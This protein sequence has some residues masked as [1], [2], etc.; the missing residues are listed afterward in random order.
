MALLSLCDDLKSGFYSDIPGE[1]VDNFNQL[2]RL[3]D[4]V[5]TFAA[6]YDYTKDLPFNGSRSILRIL[7]KFALACREP[8]ESPDSFHPTL[9]VTKLLI[10][11]TTRVIFTHEQQKSSN[12][13]V[14]RTIEVSVQRFNEFKQSRPIS[15]RRIKY[16]WSHFSL[17][18]MNTECRKITYLYTYFLSCLCQFP[19]SLACLISPEYQGTLMAKLGWTGNCFFPTN[20]G[21]VSNNPFLTGLNMAKGIFNCISTQKIQVPRQTEWIIPEGGERITRNSSGQPYVTSDKPVSIRVI[22]YNAHRPSRSVV[23]HAQGGAF[24]ID[25]RPLHESYLFNWVTQLEG[26]VIINIE[27]TRSVRF[28]IALQELLDVYIWL[29]TEDAK[30]EL[31]FEPNSTVMAGDSAGGHLV[32]VL[33]VILRDIQLASQ[34][35]IKLFP[36]ALVGFY[37]A[38]SLVHGYSASFYISSLEAFVIPSLM[39][40]I[41]S[42]YAAGIVYESECYELDNDLPRSNDPYSNPSGLTLFYNTWIRNEKTWF[43][44][45]PKKAKERFSKIYHKIL[46]PYMSPT[47]CY[48]LNLLKDLPLFLI[49]CEFDP[50]LDS[51]IAAAKRWKGSVTLDILEDLHHAFLLYSSGERAAAGSKVCLRRL[52][53]ALGINYP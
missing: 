32:F 3:S 17:F 31:G 20:I 7:D 53:Q 37:P 28:P 41:L 14:E 29:M 49:T 39:F 50:L 34:S 18:W 38:L 1:L 9:E 44:C 26:A 36:S 48:D 43:D 16:Y 42:L 46:S 40:S 51:T 27:Y 24:V 21:N 6:E 30:K 11:M 33:S 35:S 23:F 2:L 47:E 5:L 4:E 52:Q 10:D 45:E 13:S 15:E 12:D 22:R 8:L 25:A 19:I